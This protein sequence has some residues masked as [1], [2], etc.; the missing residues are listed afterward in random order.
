MISESKAASR[1]ACRLPPL[2]HDFCRLLDSH[3]RTHASLGP[4]KSTDSPGTTVAVLLLPRG[5]QPTPPAQSERLRAAS[6]PLR[7][8]PRSCVHSCRSGAMWRCVKGRR[9]SSK[10]LLSVPMPNRSLPV[11]LASSSGASCRR[12]HADGRGRRAHA[13]DSQRALDDCDCWKPLMHDYLMKAQASQACSSESDAKASRRV[14]PISY[15]LV[16]VQPRVQGRNFDFACRCQKLRQRHCA[17]SGNESCCSR[18]DDFA[19]HDGAPS[20]SESETDPYCR[21]C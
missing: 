10:Q 18:R 3:L 5:Y 7:K 17:Q 14:S 12:R 2:C 21:V 9:R 11:Q 19:S 20:R 6:V 4:V 8:A 13:S 15:V 16:P 1:E